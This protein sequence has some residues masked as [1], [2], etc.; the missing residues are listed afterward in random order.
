MAMTEQR[1]E[2]AHSPKAVAARYRAR[3]AARR[4]HAKSGVGDETR[5]TL[6]SVATTYEHIAESIEHDIGKGRLPD[7]TDTPKE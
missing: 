4:R 1:N 3:A 2:P 5:T 7:P 6:L